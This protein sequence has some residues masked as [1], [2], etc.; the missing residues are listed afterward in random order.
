[1]AKQQAAALATALHWH[2]RPIFD[3]VPDWII[4]RL[5]RVAVVNLAKVQIELGRR[6]LEA[7]L[8]AAKAAQKILG[9]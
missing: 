7:Q 2:P 9:G 1:M 5:D 4:D 3:P 8:D 6:V